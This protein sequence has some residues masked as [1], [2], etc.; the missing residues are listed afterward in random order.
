[1][2][3][4]FYKYARVYSWTFEQI[5]HFNCKHRLTKNKDTKNKRTISQETFLNLPEG[6]LNALRNSF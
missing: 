3:L 5:S 2:I 4:N 6:N 1:M